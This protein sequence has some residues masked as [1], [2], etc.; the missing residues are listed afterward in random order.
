MCNMQW[1]LLNVVR[2]ALLS[3]W[4]DGYSNDRDICLKNWDILKMIDDARLGELA[5][6]IV[7]LCTFLIVI[8]IMVHV[9]Y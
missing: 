3:S 1:G 2:H 6:S 5:I 9:L 8:N 4:L 7:I